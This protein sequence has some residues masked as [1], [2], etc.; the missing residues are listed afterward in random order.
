MKKYVCNV[1]GY[2][3]DPAAGDPDSGIAPGTAFEDIPADWVCPAFDRATGQ[4]R[5]AAFCCPSCAVPPSAVFSVHF[6][7]WDLLRSSL[8]SVGSLTG[9]FALFAALRWLPC[10]AFC[11]SAFITI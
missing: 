10:G 2:V 4:S 11:A 9:P 5:P 3:Y 7:R 8:L 6:P 1:C